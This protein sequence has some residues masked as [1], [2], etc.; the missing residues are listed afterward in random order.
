MHILSWFKYFFHKYPKYL[1][2]L[3]ILM[4]SIFRISFNLKINI[5]T[6]SLKI[7][8]C[9]VKKVVHSQMEAFSLT[10]NSQFQNRILRIPKF[11][12]LVTV[13]MSMCPQN[14][15]HCALF[16][17]F[18]SLNIEKDPRSEYLFLDNLKYQDT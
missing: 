10:A 14:V 2:Y 17:R 8:C 3:L 18:W 12:D 15:T 4:K 9:H 5:L 6:S 13:K 11:K 1:K 7:H 16:N